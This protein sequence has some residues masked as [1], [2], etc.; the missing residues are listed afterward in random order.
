[1]SMAYKQYILAVNSGSSSLKFSLYQEDNLLMALYGSA[2]PNS[3]GEQHFIIHDYRNEFLANHPLAHSG[4]LP[5]IKELINWLQ[6]QRAR[7]PIAA[8]AHRLVQGGPDHRAPEMIT[9]AL[10][11]QIH[12]YSYLAPNHIPIEL[13]V[14]KA[15]QAGF[16]EAA[17][18]ACFDTFFHRDMPGFAKYYALPARYREQ[19]LIRYGFHGL[20]YEYVMEKL[21]K[22]NP[23]VLKKKVIIAH[24][25]N[26]A[27]MV[28]VKNGQGIDTTMGLSPLGGLVM[29][30]RSGDLDPG[31]LLF[32]LNKGKL[33][34]KELDDLLS[35][36]SG[37]KAI[38]GYSDMETLVL[39]EARDDKAEEAITAFCY[40]IKKTIGALAAAMGG[41]DTLVFTGGIGENLAVIREYICQDME[42][43]GIRINPRLNYDGHHIISK[44]GGTVTVQVVATDEAAIM[45]KHTQTLISKSFVS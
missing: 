7:Y 24:L 6:G 18:V 16:P 19:G 2:K 1:M 45:A 25:G 21:V 34:V 15:F 12:Q 14:I 38:A 39:N 5:G 42:F 22:K 26:G 35:R 23:G 32:L 43:L 37:L 36:E 4:V 29:G 27:S 17:Q 40:H 28:A 9:P 8:I 41:L 11:K 31:V 13:A 10:L 20:S 44:T 30:T 33:T 3:S